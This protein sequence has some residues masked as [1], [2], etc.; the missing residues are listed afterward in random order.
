MAVSQSAFS[1]R[2]TQF[3]IAIEFIIAIINWLV[4]ALNADCLTAVV[5]QTVYHGYDKTFICTA[6][7]KLIT[8]VY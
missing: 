6:L 5:Y 3:I 4:R 7:I 2:N 8:S 1:A